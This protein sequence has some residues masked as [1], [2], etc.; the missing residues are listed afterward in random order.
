METEKGMGIYGEILRKVPIEKSEYVKTAEDRAYWAR[1]SKQ[2]A[3][4]EAKHGPNIVFD[5]PSEW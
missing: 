2:V 5:F 3:E 4:I 1:L